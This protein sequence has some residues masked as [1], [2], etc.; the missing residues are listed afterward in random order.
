MLDMVSES[1]HYTYMET[2]HTNSTPGFYDYLCAFAFA[3][4]VEYDSTLSNAW[5]I[6]RQREHIIRECFNI[7]LPISDAIYTVMFE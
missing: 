5:E 3:L 2:D 7:N 1:E 6:I 4:T